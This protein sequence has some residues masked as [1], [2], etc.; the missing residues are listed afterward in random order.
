MRFY[1][2]ILLSIFLIAFNSTSF[3][4][5]IE[6]Q[7]SSDQ[8]T[9][10]DSIFVTYLL[11]NADRRSPDF[12]VL[13]KDFRI[14]HTNYDTTIK[15][16]N[17]STSMQTLWRLRLEP[18]HAGDII[19]PE[20]NFGNDK[21]ATRKLIVTSS[22]VNQEPQSNGTNPSVF[23]RAEVSS[24]SP[25]VQS[26][27]LYTFKLFFRTQLN[28]PRIEMPQIKDAT[29]FQLSEKQP[30]QTTVN[31]KAYNVIEK[32]LV[33]FPQKPGTLVVP[34]M[35]FHALAVEENGTTY[36]DLLNFR[37]MKTVSVAT[38][39]FHLK[40][41][42]VPANYQGKIWLP[43]KN[44]SVSD[45]WSDNSKQWESDTPVMRT[46][47]IEA[48][49]LRADQ[50]PDLTFD[51]INGVSVYVD[52]PKRSNQVRDNMLVGLYEQK[53]TYIP[54]NI[55][56]AII[57]PLKINWWNTQ[58]DSNAVAQTNGMTVHVKTVAG[59]V[60]PPAMSLPAPV[61]NKPIVTLPEAQPVSKAF[62][63][64]VWFWMAGTFLIGW[65]VTL[66]ILLRKNSVTNKEIVHQPVEP[67]EKNFE[68]ACRS[69]QAELAQ[70]Y[71]LDWAKTQWPD[72]PLNLTSL[73]T[74]IHNEA[75]NLALQKLERA[76][77]AEK[78]AP[79]NGESLL[80]A[81]QQI[82]KT[83]KNSVGKVKQPIEILPPL[84]P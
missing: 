69:G 31:G 65:I 32:T 72:A 5:T 80:V 38:K 51:K 84:N 42:D 21:S 83:R 1:R 53:I 10:G 44:I 28:D 49:G 76:L 43:A 36:D 62:Y 59:A 18:L 15:M 33:L 50:L 30:Y 70:Q 55:N 57:P 81:F 47:T 8:I 58:T 68:I 23:V 48:Q 64:S 17:G 37:E 12:S 52:R 26:Q 4:S 3:A 63:T 71:L 61:I 19:I 39:D 73:R 7:L 79:W 46:I 11:N 67:N 2:L 82:K 77:Y 25:Y 20:I 74:F 22:P 6:T 60:Q 14:L 54:N 35:Q 13:Q 34:P 41:R 66:W 40:V 16:I 78:T 45:Q 24:T 27:V 9:L 56:S 29:F 75:F